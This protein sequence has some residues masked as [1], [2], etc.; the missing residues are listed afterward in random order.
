MLP[1]A[2]ADDYRPRG[3]VAAQ[4]GIAWRQLAQLAT[5]ARQH[6]GH[7]L[8]RDKRAAVNLWSKAIAES[9]EEERRE[10]GNGGLRA[11]SKSEREIPKV[12]YK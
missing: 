12:R 2:T 4:G 1:R 5:L 9:V 11:V 6:Y 10:G 7:A 8:P 3:G